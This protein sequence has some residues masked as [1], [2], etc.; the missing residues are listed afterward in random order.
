MTAPPDTGRNA[1]LL[2]F[3]LLIP[4]GWYIIMNG[5]INNINI[6]IANIYDPNTDDPDISAKK[7]EIKTNPRW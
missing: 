3:V 1:M 2:L 5:T 6:T 4:E 7:T